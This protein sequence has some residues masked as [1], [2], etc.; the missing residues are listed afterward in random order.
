MYLYRSEEVDINLFQS[1]VN[2]IKTQPGPIKYIWK[3]APSEDE[4]DSSVEARTDIS[5]DQEGEVRDSAYGMQGNAELQMYP[6]KYLFEQ[7]ED[8]RSKNKIQDKDV[9]VLFTDHGNERNFFSA[10]DPTGRYN[11][12]IQT[13][14]WGNF[15]ES[16][17]DYPIIYELASI[18]LAIIAFDNMDE[19]EAWAHQRARGC[20]FDYCKEKEDVQL[21]LRTADIC[22][23]CR[24]R[25]IDRQIDV[26]LVA[27]IFATFESI[28]TQMLYRSRFRLTEI[29]SD[30]VIDKRRKSLTF[31]NIGNLSFKL[32]P[33]EMA[34]YLFFL[35]HP[36]G[37]TYPGMAR[38]RDELLNIYKSVNIREGQDNLK[39]V[40]DNILRE[41]HDT[42][43][44]ILSNIRQKFR[45]H[46]GEEMAKPYIVDPVTEN[47]FGISLDRDYVEI[48]G[49]R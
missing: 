9:V 19:V 21:R 3:E 6:W 48:R 27:Q 15:I 25:L 45:Q 8:I 29:Y 26:A 7:C 37:V 41:P 42:K 14:D 28:R 38:Y 44:D 33:R 40:V 13:S 35:N 1:I 4:N 47:K 22:K 10:W 24:Q 46:F 5:Q 2:R 43:H 18:P 16:D 23:E 36:E 32:S 11:F 49:G 34:I 17:P 31:P 39:N 30:M 12:F 20:V